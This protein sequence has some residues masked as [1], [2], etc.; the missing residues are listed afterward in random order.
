LEV[1]AAAAAEVLQKERES[2]TG[3]SGDV[4]TE[5]ATKTIDGSTEGADKP[6]GVSATVAADT[7]VA[8]PFAVVK[9]ED[10]SKGDADGDE[11]SEG[12]GDG[13][14]Q[15]DAPNPNNPPRT[16]DA[17]EDD[18]VFLGLRV[19]TNKASPAVVGGQ[20]RHEMATSFAGLAIDG[21]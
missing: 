4:P 9:I 12:K 14:P 5:E 8:K 3:K 15:N 6:T 11:D 16:S 20:L 21:L 18:I 19:Y 13:S 7:D 10:N 17:S 1:K 2:L